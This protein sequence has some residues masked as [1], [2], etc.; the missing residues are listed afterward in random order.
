MA[1]QEREQPTITRVL[2]VQHGETEWS[3]ED[4]FAGTSDVT[5]SE[6]GH[7]QAAQLAERLKGERLAAVYSSPLY[8]ALET[9]KVIAA[10]HR[11]QPTVVDGLREM[12]FGDWEGRTRGSV[13]AEYAPV[14]AA[15]TRDPAT[16]RTPH[17]E[18]G[19]EV[20]ARA[21]AAVK[22]LARMHVGETILVAGHRTVNRLVLCQ[23]LGIGL[24]G[25]RERLA[26]DVGALNCVD[27]D[28]RGRGHL[29]FLNDISHLDEQREVR[30]RARPQPSPEPTGPGEGVCTW[31]VPDNYLPTPLNDGQAFQSHEA[32]CVLNTGTQD[33]QLHFDFFFEDRP[34]IPDVPVTVPAQRTLHIRLDRPEQLNG[35]E[36][37][38]DVPFAT[39]IRSDQPVVVQHSRLDT[40][41]TNLALMTTIA[42]PVVNPPATGSP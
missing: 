22:D 25:Y 23:L 13:I 5:L 42:Y 29:I 38:R 30:Q 39:R 2:L 10:P 33:V 19:F 27:I 20:A 24:S 31:I 41:Q 32:L 37:P 18:S 21:A 11:L 34:C 1:S 3:R 8:R 35:T 26:Q 7:W 4:R 28:A 15:W 9:A 14:Y 6:R 17:G 36:L 16:V 12:D 40:S